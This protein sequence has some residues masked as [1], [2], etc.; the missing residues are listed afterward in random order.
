MAEWVRQ[1]EVPSKNDG[2]QKTVGTEGRWGLGREN[3]L[4]ALDSGSVLSSYQVLVEIVQVV[5]PVQSPNLWCHGNEEWIA[6]GDRIVRTGTALSSGSVMLA[7]QNFLLKMHVMG[8][9]KNGKLGWSKG[10]WSK[11]GADGP[12]DISCGSHGYRD[13]Q[14]PMV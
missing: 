12:A 10:R 11:K 13:I 8:S 6:D 3:L 1:A 14:G 4:R 2:S 5:F 7:G 9:I